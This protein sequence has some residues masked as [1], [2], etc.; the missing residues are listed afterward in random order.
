DMHS[1]NWYIYCDTGRSEEW[2]ILPWD[3]DLSY[4]RFWN[5]TDTYFDNRLYT[6]GYVVTG[7]AIRLVAQMFGNPDMRAMIMRR[8]RTLSDRYLAPPPEAGTDENDLYCERRLNEQLALIDPP[9]IV[10]SDA[11]RDFEKWGSWLQGGTVVAYDNPNPAVESMVE[12]IDRWKTEYLPARRSYL[13]NTQTVDHG[14]EIPLPQVGG[15]P[16]V[17]YTPLVVAGA[18]VRALVPADS[19]LGWKWIGVPTL[20][21]FDDS[22]WLSGVTG[23]GYERGT[24]YESLIGLN[25]D[26]QMRQN[27][28]VF[29]RIEFDLADPSAI[30]QLELRM[31]YDDGFVAFLNGTLLVSANSPEPLSWDSAALHSQE[32]NR[33]AYMTFDVTDK[34]FSLRAGRNIL[35]IQGLNDSLSSSD[36]LFVPSLHAG[37]VVP[38]STGEPEIEFGTIES[39]PASGDQD[40]E[41]IELRNP[42]SIAVDISDWQ[43][44]GAIAHTFLGGTVLPPNGRLYVCPSAAAFRARAVSP[45]GGEGLFVQGGYQGHLTGLGGT[46]ALLDT[47]GNTNNTATFEAQPSDPQRY[48]VVS[49]LMYHP[50]VNAEAEFIELLNISETTTLDLAGIRFTQGVDFDFTGSDITSL[51]PGVRVLVVRDLA[52]FESVYGTGLPIAGAFA[53]GTALSNGGELLRLEDAGHDRI[54]EFAYADA[55]PWPDADGNGFSLV[56]V[57]PET[58]PDHALPENWRTSTRTGGSPGGPDATPFEGDPMADTDGNGERDLIDYALGNDLGGAPIPTRI[59]LHPAGPGEAQ[60]LWLLHPISLVTT[61]VELGVSFSTD[62]VTWEDAGTSL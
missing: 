47:A 59:E 45:R 7:T 41:Y 39:S 62:L 50:A 58:N 12:A 5:P 10:P 27:N 18:R 49:E 9:D 21:P 55:A 30:D 24:G 42:H 1:K 11:Q 16:T 48:L 51:P 13:Y 61:G 2:A 44:A 56:L 43:L 8:I 36:L 17:D 25:V 4:G 46:V 29:L 22:S 53:N 40:E 52:A 19:S 57:A 31:K 34:K 3:L 26:T 15:G 37:T 23:V 32:A 35:A 54:R 20:E 33:N 28:S 60:E 38:P 14:G 6:D